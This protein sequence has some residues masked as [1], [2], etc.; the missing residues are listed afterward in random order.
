MGPEHCSTSLLFINRDQTSESFSR[1][2]SDEASAVNSH[3]Q[4]WRNE[5]LRQH[6]PLPSPKMESKP[7]NLP[8]LF[9]NKGQ[10]SAS[11]SKSRDDEAAIINSHTQRWR[12]QKIRQQKNDALRSKSVATRRVATSGWRLKEVEYKSAPSSNRIQTPEQEDQALADALRSKVGLIAVE[13][14]HG[15]SIYGE[16]YQILQANFSEGDCIDPFS[17]TA[18][19]IGKEIQTILQYYL[20][21]SIPATYKAESLPENHAK[22]SLSLTHRHSPTVRQV[23]HGAL[24]NKM[25][26]YALLTATAGRMKYVSRVGLPKDNSAEAFIQKAIAS[27]RVYLKSCADSIVDKQVI[28]D[29]FFLCVCEWYL[30]NYDAALMHLAAVGHLMKSLDLTSKFDQYIQETACHNDV[31]LSIETLTP[32]LFPLTWDVPPLTAVQ[33]VQIYTELSVFPEYR[34]MGG[35]FTSVLS[36]HV[37]SPAMEAIFTELMIWTDVAQYTWICKTAT[38]AD[39]EWMSRKGKAMLHRLLSIPAISSKDLTVPP[40]RRKE[41]CCR[42]VLIILLSYISTQMAWRSGKMNVA[43]LKTALWNVDRDWGS[44]SLNHMLLWVLI[45]GTFAAEGTTD[46]EWFVSRVLQVARIL[47]VRSYD[48]LEEVMCQFFYSSKLQHANVR[49]LTDRILKEERKA[50]DPYRE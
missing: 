35:G 48:K 26:M 17:V 31:F 4:R 21:L 18:V 13:P 15:Q 32:P 2:S 37:F 25:H 9:I 29:V 34:R 1:S 19:P 36:Q 24:F 46:E 23:V 39:A 43:R 38:K 33:W 42:F 49:K 44:E 20:A 10:E 7:G 30:Q 40:P 3:A 22:G 45:C 8:L 27:I 47:E 14:T 6:K 5:Q 50:P 12:N 16:D 41:E 28:M 11:F